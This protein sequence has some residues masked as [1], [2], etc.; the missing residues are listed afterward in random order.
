MLAKANKSSWLCEPADFYVDARGLEVCQAQLKDIDNA[1]I[2]WA[3]GE[4][5]G[6]FV[7]GMTMDLLGPKICASVG[8]VQIHIDTY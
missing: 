3:G 8:A 5:V 2:L 1:F 6:S 4:L 7:A